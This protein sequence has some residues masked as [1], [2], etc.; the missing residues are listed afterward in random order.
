MPHDITET[1]KY[2]AGAI[3]L[4]DNGE[5][6]GIE[7]IEPAFQELMDRG[8]FARNAVVGRLSWAG[9]LAVNRG[10]TLTSFTITLGA[11]QLCAL[12]DDTGADYQPYAYAG[13][14]I[15]QADIEGGGGTLGASAQ[16]WYVYAK[17]DT[18]NTLDFEISTSAPRA[19]RVL[20]SPVN[21]TT[22][23]RRYLGCFPTTSAGAP[24]PVTASRGC[25]RYRDRA[26][27]LHLSQST[28]D[29]ATF[30]SALSLATLVPPHAR[31]AIVRLQ[32]L[33]S[34]TLGDASVSIRV[35]GDT[36]PAA[37]FSTPQLPLL[38]VDERF[39]EMDV[40]ASREV[41]VATNGASTLV[42]VDVAGWRE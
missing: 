18:S 40:G 15:T 2:T 31:V 27:A 42:N 19:H 41:Q 38:A 22:Y 39:I 37:T 6:D 11:V 8:A 34:G 16:W 1:A 30:T 36:N 20:K 4:P 7:S 3:E 35:N 12:P 29:L 23:A 32:I 17:P 5:T 25:Y 33:R 13:G 26:V 10:G 28:S 9:D 14:N 21:T 24:I